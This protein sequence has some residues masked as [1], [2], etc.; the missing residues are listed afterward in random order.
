MARVLRRAT[1]GAVL[2]LVMTM[3]VSGQD[4]TPPAPVLAGSWSAIP[5][6]PWGTVFSA[7]AF[8]GSEVL[9]VDLPTG[10]TLGYDLA[11]RVWTRHARAP[12][13]FDHLSPSVW[14]GTELLV[15]DRG[16]PARN[17]AYDPEADTWRQLA[18]SPLREQ[19]VAAWADGQAVVGDRKEG[20]AAYD[21]ATDTWRS[22]PDIPGGRILDSLDWTGEVV[23]AVTSGNQRSRPWITMLDPAIDRW[24]KPDKGPLDGRGWGAEWVGDRLLVVLGPGSRAAAAFDPV[25]DEWNTIEDYDCPVL[26]GNAHWTGE[27]LVSASGEHAYDP[28]TGTC[29]RLPDP[30]VW[31]AFND[32]DTRAW[33]TSLWTGEELLW[34]SGA[35]GD[36]E[37]IYTDGIAFRPTPAA[38]DASGPGE[39]SGAVTP[40]PSLVPGADPAPIG[41]VTSLPL[42]LWPDAPVPAS[43]AEYLPAAREQ[44]WDHASD[45]L[46]FPLHLR[47]VEA[48][49]SRDG[50][51][52]LVFEEIGPP[53]GTT[54]YAYAV[55]GSMPTSPDDGWGGGYGVRSVL[56]DP[57]FIHL[58]GDDTVVCP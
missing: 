41:T 18:D 38:G 14:T 3:P 13:R 36:S 37:T 35:Y 34:W 53:I 28:V 58:M 54:T 25:T 48:R 10:R 43:L 12:Q 30:K 17:Y 15:F 55:R 40:G 4:A 46:R 57:E 47:F 5:D 44:L 8:T 50:G 26:T 9:I 7:T 51:V 23:L 49:C 33:A 39:P 31:A 19:W 29:Y 1:V 22:L 45:G 11:T 6:A 20:M 42:Y 2:A 52:A 16:E 56:D 24:T 27:L 32:D 21:L